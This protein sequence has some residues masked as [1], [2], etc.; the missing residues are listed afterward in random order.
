MNIHRTAPIA[1]SVFLAAWI[2]LPTRVSAVAGLADTVIILEDL[3]DL[4]KWPREYTQWQQVIRNTATQISR[5]NEL[6]KQSDKLI[7][8][9]DEVIRLL[10]ETQN[11]VNRTIGSVPDILKP[12]E[13]ALALESEKHAVQ[14][15]KNLFGPGSKSVKV[16]NPVNQVGATYEAAGKTFKRDTGRYSHFAAQEALYARYRTAGTMWDSVAEKELGVQ[17]AAMQ[18]L[19]QAKTDAEVAVFEATIA[20]SKQRQDLAHQK[21]VQAKADLDA[22]RDQ[23]RVEENRKAEAD[24]EWAQE[25]VTRMREKALAA[26]Q[27]QLGGAAPSRH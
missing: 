2:S 27:A 24:R 25:V 22:F 11:A 23:L 18:R 15:G 13:Q 7:A 9:S 19:K 21:T 12:A 8:R 26:Y 3:T 14:S 4:W 6:I 10:G 16:Y 5:T 17:R 1:A 20:A